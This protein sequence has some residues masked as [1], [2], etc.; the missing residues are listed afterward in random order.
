M[1]GNIAVENSCCSTP[2]SPEKH[3]SIKA[4]TQSNIEGQSQSSFDIA[5]A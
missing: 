3:A 4:A 5:L 2:L 1:E